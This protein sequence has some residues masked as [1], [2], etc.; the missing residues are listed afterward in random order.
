M[1]VFY[2]Q[3][4][5]PENNRAYELW[6]I[7]IV[8]WYFTSNIGIIIILRH[9]SQNHYPLLNFQGH[10]SNIHEDGIFYIFITERKFIYTS[11]LLLYKVRYLF[12]SNI[13]S[14]SVTSHN[15]LF[16]NLKIE[17]F[18]RN[19]NNYKSSEICKIKNLKLLEISNQI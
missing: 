18:L 1:K 8:T 16:L 15:Y 19:Q 5:V 12:L 9:I 6:H 10:L 14:R 4:F 13:F 11:T 7:T 3:R 2:F 17:K